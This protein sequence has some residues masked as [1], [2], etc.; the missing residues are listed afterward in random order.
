MATVKKIPLG[1]KPGEAK[2]VLPDVVTVE[3]THLVGKVKQGL[4]A[5][6]VGVGLEV[7][8]T[9]LDED[10]TTIVG[11]RGKWNPDRIATRHGAERSSMV[12]GG[13]RVAV[14]KPRARSVAGQEIPLPTWNA[15][16]GDDLLSEMAFD[17]M[18]AGLSTR[19]YEV[20]LEPVG[21]GLDESGTGRSAVAR[22]FKARTTKALADLMGK[23]LSELDICA[24][25]ADGEDVGDHTVV[26]ALGIDRQGVK[27]PVGIA[28][29]STE[30]EA[31]CTRLFNDLVRRGLEF[32]QGILLVLDGGKGLRAA[33][34]KVFGALGL[35][36]RC[37]IHKERNVL[38]HLPDYMKAGVRKK[39]HRAYAERD[40]HKA[41]SQLQQLAHFLEERHP[42]AA[43]SLREG[44]EETLTITRLGIPPGLS[45]TLFSTNT[46]ESM[47][48]VGRTT[49]RN[50]K[51][52]RNGKMVCRWVAAGTEVAAKQFRKVKGYT[53]LTPVLIEALAAHAREVTEER[54]GKVA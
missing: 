15:F 33:A 39:L 3:L 51:R 21:D 35:V 11:E 13:R 54:S 40:P 38:R 10:V 37:R 8:H 49:M 44:M 6:S 4:L 32:S 14:D 17:R 31:V 53:E 30:S 23:D 16:Q 2:V 18:I 5:F 45:K 46:V 20:G 34:R 1:R 7:I 43:A 50:V 47:I 25:I 22:R 24:V 36:Q 26:V 28:E 12:L 29:G 19:N 42:G 52:W 41:L 9:L 27:H 48:S